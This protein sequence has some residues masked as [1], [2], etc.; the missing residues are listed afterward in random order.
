MQAQLNWL[1]KSPSKTS[2]YDKS[3]K[4]KF[5]GIIDCHIEIEFEYLL[6]FTNLKNY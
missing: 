6:E 1:K 3:N 4:M 2:M 5:M